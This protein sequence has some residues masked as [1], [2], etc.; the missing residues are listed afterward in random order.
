MVKNAFSQDI[1]SSILI[2]EKLALN[3]LIV[4]A[5]DVISM[6]ININQR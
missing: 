2:T 4:H 1:V 6:G 3:L 5:K